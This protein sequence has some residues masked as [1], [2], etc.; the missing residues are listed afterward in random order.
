MRELAIFY[1]QYA[2]LGEDGFYHVIPTVSAEHW[3]WTKNFERNRDT[4]SAL[5]LFKWLLNTTAD[6]SEL[7]GRDADLRDRWRDVA[8]K[9][10]PY[11]TYDT[12]EGP[13][14]DLSPD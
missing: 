6:A 4:T 8:S 3:A 9:M 11:P 14:F 12:P 10:A 5:C 1:S 13:V 7:L 2:T